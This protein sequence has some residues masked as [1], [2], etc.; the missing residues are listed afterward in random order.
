MKRKN[1]NQKNTRIFH[2]LGFGVCCLFLAE[3]GTTY[4]QNVRRRKNKTALKGRIS[5]YISLLLFVM[6]I[7]YFYLSLICIFQS[8]FSFFLCLYL[9]KTHKLLIFLVIYM[10]LNKK[11]IQYRIFQSLTEKNL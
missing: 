7:F 4:S 1:V 3:C 11:N 8:V 10:C 2:G 5:L 9:P 6:L